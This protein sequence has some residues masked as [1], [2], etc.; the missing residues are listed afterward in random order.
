M[1]DDW[2]VPSKLAV[3]TGSTSGIGKETA[4]A[5]AALGA[6]V[7]LACRNVEL[8]A[9]VAADIRRQHP[10][11]KV[12]V[13]PQLDLASQRSVRRFAQE[14]AGGGRPINILVNNAG[15]NHHGEPWHTEDGVGGLCQVN[16]L[17]PYTLTRLLEPVLLASAPARVVN[18]SSVTHRYGR[19]PTSLAT[20]LQDWRQGSYYPTTKLAN[21]LFAYELQRR[22]GA[23]GIQ[24]CAVE[25]GGV[26]TSIWKGSRFSRPPL[27]W[28]INFLYA[29]PRDGAQAVIHAATMPWGAD[30]R[31]AQQVNA[32]W[33]SR[34]RKASALG[35]NTSTNGSSAGGR[36]SWH[37]LGGAKR[38]A[39]QLS[40][41]SGASESSDGRSSNG[42]IDAQHDFRFYAKGLFASPWVTNWRGVP[43]RGPLDQARGVVWGLG[44]IVCS[45]LDWP[46]RNLSNGRWQSH[47]RCV[48]AAPLSYDEQLAKGLWEVS[49]EV[50]GVPVKPA[51][52]TKQQP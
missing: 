29:P 19:A 35:S 21:V 41:S 10:G 16:Y 45:L 46:I 44:T 1:D 15:A 9:Q 6:T 52:P 7:V 4:A 33:A 51:V 5:L 30:R 48:P 49:A 47:V 23:H 14:W 50:A 8:A 13:G 22:L 17:G 24:S 28:V 3:V 26:A 31:Q 11:S 25:P 37:S 34:Y 27:S 32:R 36:H 40:S 12:E 18:V 39:R 42:L 2:D 38:G 20:F 43:T